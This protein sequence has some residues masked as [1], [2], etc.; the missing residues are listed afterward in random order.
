MLL[1]AD[2]E[3]AVNC[4]DLGKGTP[5]FTPKH[6]GCWLEAQNG[7]GNARPLEELLADSFRTASRCDST[8]RKKD[9]IFTSFSRGRGDCCQTTG[10][11]TTNTGT[12]PPTRHASIES[13]FFSSQQRSGVSGQLATSIEK[14]GKHRRSPASG[15]DPINADPTAM[16]GVSRGRAAKS[17]ELLPT[18][19]LK[20]SVAAALV[21]LQ[22]SRGLT[23]M[24][25]MHEAQQRSSLYRVCTESKRPIKGIWEIAFYSPTLGQNNVCL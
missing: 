23:L 9:K 17:L 16:A 14:V 5:C 11:S 13:F 7:F 21:K 25:L 15:R 18:I 20:S 22:T 10:V 24:Q 1:Q 2:R 6:P 19:R 12:I 8:P 3:Q 4:Q